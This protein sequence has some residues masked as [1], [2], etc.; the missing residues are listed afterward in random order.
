MYNMSFY[1]DFNKLLE[2]LIALSK[3]HGI[4]IE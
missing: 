4:S 2:K 1:I 3:K